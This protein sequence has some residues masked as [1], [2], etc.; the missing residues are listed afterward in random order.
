MADASWAKLSWLRCSNFFLSSL[1]F[2]RTSVS[3]F[4]DSETLNIRML[5]TIAEIFYSANKCTYELIFADAGENIS[6]QDA[7]LENVGS[8]VDSSA[9][10]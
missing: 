7:A 4:R 6:E 3:I 10:A 2:F 8:S 9:V 1:G 5:S